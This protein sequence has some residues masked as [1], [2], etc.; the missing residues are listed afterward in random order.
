MS[1]I[2]P[3]EPVKEKIVAEEIV[4]EEEPALIIEGEDG[5]VV[6][7]TELA[8]SLSELKDKVKAAGMRPLQ[9]VITSYASTILGAVDGL[10]GALEGKKKK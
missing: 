8:E 9:N 2:K 1:K 10:L 6:S 5:K 4:A 3:E 7:S